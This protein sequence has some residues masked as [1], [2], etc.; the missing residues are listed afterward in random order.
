[1]LPTFLGIGAPKSGSSW[2]HDLLASHPQVWMAP[3][4]EVHYFDRHYDRGLDWYRK[5]FPPDQHRDRYVAAGEIT[6]HY[7]YHA[8]GAER[9]AGL[10]SVRRLIVLLRNPVDR[11]YSHYW[12]RARIENY[13]GSFEEFLADRPEATDWGFYARHLRSYVARFDKE[14]FSILIFEHAFDNPDETLRR[15]G[16]ALG[17][18]Y[19]R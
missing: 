17:L 9:I 14:R 2:L 16:D 6:P 8:R 13:T 3:R 18:R 15:L 7:M 5:F 1:M 10:P 11:A 19:Y 4:R 12:F